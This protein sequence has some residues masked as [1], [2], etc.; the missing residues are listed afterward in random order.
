VDLGIAGR[1]ALVTGA[2]SGLG[3]AVAR[4]LAM[5]G[6][7][8]AVVARRRDELARVAAEIASESQR[9]VLPLVADVTDAEATTRAVRDTTESLGPVDI[10]VANAGGP[11]V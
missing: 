6:V 5:E 10:L 9:R 2:S 7:S 4:E 11:P 8:V 1:V 3:R